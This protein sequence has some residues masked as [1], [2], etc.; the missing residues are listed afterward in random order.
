MVVVVFGP[1]W[2]GWQGSGSVLSFLS[3]STSSSS[4]KYSDSSSSSSSCSCIYVCDP[5]DSG[6]SRDRDGR[7]HDGMGPSDA[8]ATLLYATI[9]SGRDADRKSIGRHTMPC[10]RLRIVM[11]GSV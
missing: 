11:G 8:T 1:V 4:S 5:R 3:S 9:I 6:T 10:H 2:S 7:R